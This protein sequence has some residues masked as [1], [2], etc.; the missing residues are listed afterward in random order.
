MD[1]ETSRDAFLKALQKH[2]VP[3]QAPE[4]DEEFVYRGNVKKDLETTGLEYIDIDD[5]EK[6]REEMLEQTAGEEADI[7]VSLTQKLLELLGKVAGA[8]EKVLLFI[9]APIIKPFRK[10]A[11]TIT[12]RDWVVFFLLLFGVGAF[13][14][15]S[16][17]AVKVQDSCKKPEDA[18]VVTM[19]YRE[20]MEGKGKLT[21]E[22]DDQ[23]VMKSGDQEMNV[24]S[25]PVYSASEPE[26]LLP[27][28][29]MWYDTDSETFGKT[30]RY[31][32]AELKDGVCTVTQ[33]HG[34]QVTVGGFLY[35]NADTYL[36]L[37]PVSLEY[38]G[39]RMDLPALSYVKV[40]EQGAIDIYPYGGEGIYDGLT[41]DAVMKFAGGGSINLGMDIMYY[42]N[43]SFR[44]LYTGLDAI[45]LLK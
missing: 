36:T 19:G 22:S 4:E 7:P 18:Y 41:T 23:V 34:A 8:G 14:A 28:T 30:A 15:A 25:V 10:G 13:I 26:V 32:E 27:W 2:P 1:K 21:V 17:V 31:A 29:G 6:N 20:N 37:E 42:A 38:N 33:R 9:F 40:Q 35:D 44:L 45:S 5:E 43:G 16:R 24:T 39:T 3:E 11:D 12:R